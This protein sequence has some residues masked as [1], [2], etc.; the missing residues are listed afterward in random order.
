MIVQM[1]FEDFSAGPSAPDQSGSDQGDSLEGYETGYK[2]GWDDALKSHQDSKTHISTSLAQNLEQIEFTLIE[3]KAEVI[4]SI[5]PVLNEITNTLFPSLTN[6]ALRDLIAGEIEAML[7]TNSPTDVSII[8]SEQD[9]ATI[10][11]LLN[12][13]NALSEISLV[14]KNTVGEG[15]A[16]IS[17][18]A[19]QRKIDVGQAL[20]DI[21]ST[22]DSFLN[23]PELER[24]N[25]T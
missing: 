21:Q 18:N 4:A 25:A 22:I 5:K 20:A 8:V 23:Q 16:Y 1:I 7:K 15:Q 11:T 10:A 19:L 17:C 6:I 12:S 9:E 24:A 3:A 2:A 14:A 13:T